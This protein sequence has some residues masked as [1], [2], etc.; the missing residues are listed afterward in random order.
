MSSLSSGQLSGLFMAACA[1]AR[2][3]GHSTIG[4]AFRL[5]L[6]RPPACNTFP[7]CLPA[8]DIQRMNLRLP[9]FPSSRVHVAWLVLILLMTMMTA[10]QPLLESSATEPGS[11][12]ASDSAVAAQVLPALAPATPL[13]FV[14]LPAATT[15]PGSSAEQAIMASMNRAPM[16]VRLL[17]PE[18]R[19][20]VAVEVMAW[21]T[22]RIN[23]ERSTRWV[24][25]E[26]AAGW[27]VSSAAAGEPGNMILMGRQLE[28]GVFAPIAQSAVGIGQEV[29]VY[30]SQGTLYRYMID[31]IS[32]PLSLMG[33][34]ETETRIAA[35]LADTNA[36]TLTLITGWPDFTTTH[37]IFVRASLIQ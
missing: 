16:P 19:M 36:P 2:Q 31:E 29:H 23:G 6:H 21:E 3:P 37:R 13:P 18:A 10:C 25:P 30:D 9:V 8:P 14:P 5:C 12:V 35:Y 11:I 4:W 24:F 22:T 28:G 27:Q 15:S 17:I 7:R 32:E 33:D 34:G 1:R 26:G 20:D